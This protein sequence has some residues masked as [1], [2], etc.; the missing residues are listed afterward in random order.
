VTKHHRHPLG[1]GG[2]GVSALKRAAGLNTGDGGAAYR[3]DRGS[4]A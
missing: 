3:L 1:L 2:E 4:A